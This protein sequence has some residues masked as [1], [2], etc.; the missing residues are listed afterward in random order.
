MG[1]MGLRTSV[2]GV[3]SRCGRKSPA[4]LSD[5]GDF[6]EIWQKEPDLPDLRSDGQTPP[7]GL[8]DSSRPGG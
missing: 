2:G 5:Q 7:P 6:L 8:R 3:P 4:P 1:P